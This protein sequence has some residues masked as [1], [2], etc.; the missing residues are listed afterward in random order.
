MPEAKHEARP[1]DIGLSKQRSSPTLSHEVHQA[2]TALDNRLVEVLERGDIRL[3]RGAW[4][5]AQPEDF[6]I[7]KRQDIEALEMG[8]SPS[9][10]LSPEE[11][12]DLIRGGSRSVGVLSYGCA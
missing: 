9:P 11:A 1:V 3:M 8:A 10:L 6:R 4:L 12:V 2:L 5:L 7:S